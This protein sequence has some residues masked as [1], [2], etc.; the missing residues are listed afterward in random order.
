MRTAPHGKGLLSLQGSGGGGSSEACFEGLISK[1]EDWRWQEGGRH[2]APLLLLGHSRTHVVLALAA[3][4]TWD[5]R[6]CCRCRS[7]PASARR[8]RNPGAPA[9]ARACPHPEGGRRPP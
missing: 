4:A 8:T 2:S 5:G 7:S 1:R 3:A 9:R 6:S